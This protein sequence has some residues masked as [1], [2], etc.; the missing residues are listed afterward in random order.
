MPSL[1]HTAGSRSSGVHGAW[2][3]DSK[4]TQLVLD[5][6]RENGKRHLDRALGLLIAEQLPWHA[7]LLGVIPP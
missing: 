6:T 1:Y 2:P 7:H 3:R 4:S 5:E